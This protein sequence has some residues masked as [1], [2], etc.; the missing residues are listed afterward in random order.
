M[1]PNRRPTQGAEAKA[2]RERLEREWIDGQARRQAE[3]TEKQE[4]NTND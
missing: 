1:K 4:G 2:I 3:K